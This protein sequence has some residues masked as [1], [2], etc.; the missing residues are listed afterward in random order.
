[1]KYIGQWYLEGYWDSVKQWRH[2]LFSDKTKWTFQ[3]ATWGKH[4][5]L[6]ADW[7]T[8]L[9]QPRNG[10]HTVTCVS[11]D[12]SQQNNYNFVESLKRCLTGNQVA[13]SSLLGRMAILDTWRCTWASK[14]N[15]TIMDAKK[16][17]V[18]DSLGIGYISPVWQN[19]EYMIVM[20]MLYISISRSTIWL[21]NSSPWKITIYNS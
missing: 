9:H 1:M 19:N 14:K 5:R 7:G 15:A 20:R 2:T 3:T 12:L 4:V 18:W 10:G 17:L 11:Y 21:F 6:G 16:P 13:F 8:W